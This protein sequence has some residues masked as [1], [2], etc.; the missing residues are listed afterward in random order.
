MIEILLISFYVISAILCGYFIYKL[1]V[2]EL[3]A[4]LGIINLGTL[5]IRVV[6]P[7]IPVAN[8]LIL[9]ALFV[10]FLYNT[11]IKINIKDKNE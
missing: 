5:F 8:A 6:T 10:Q 4:G 1:T 7:L 9:I 11:D 3:K 2:K